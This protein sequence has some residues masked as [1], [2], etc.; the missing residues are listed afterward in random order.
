MTQQMVFRGLLDLGDGAPPRLLDVWRANGAAVAFDGPTQVGVALQTVLSYTEDD[1]L[2]ITGVNDAGTPVT[3]TGSDPA[4]NRGQWT[5][6]RVRYPD[7]NTVTGATI[8]WTQ[9]GVIIGTAGNA[10]L[11]L[12]GARTEVTGSQRWIVDGAQRYAVES[13]AKSCGSCGR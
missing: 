11:V 9:Y 1:R 4:R 3:W 6:M 2:Q 8:T 5:G 13:T 12:P 7:G 10:N